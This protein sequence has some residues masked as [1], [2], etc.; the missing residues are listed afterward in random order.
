MNCARKCSIRKCVCW[1]NR[2]NNGRLNGKRG[3]GTEGMRINRR[4]FLSLVA[5]S[6]AVKPEAILKAS[7]PDLPPTPEIGDRYI[8]MPWVAWDTVVLK[9]QKRVREQTFF[10]P[11]P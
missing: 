2:G 4:S 1:S 3:A 6:L 8:E 10:P 9:P 11:L 5:A 7:D